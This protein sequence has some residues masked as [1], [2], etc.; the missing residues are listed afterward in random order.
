M[1]CCS[2]AAC[3]TTWKSSHPSFIHQRQHSVLI[4][5][6]HP[7]II[8]AILTSLIPVL[9]CS[10]PLA[11]SVGLA[12]QT[13]SSIFRRPRGMYFSAID[14][15]VMHSMMWNWPTSDVE[16]IVVTDGSR[17]LGLGDLG[18]NGMGIP[19]GKLSLYTAGAG[20]HP[21]KT[22]PVLID[23]GTNNEKLLDDPMYLGLPQKRVSGPEYYDIV[24]EFIQ[25]VRE[26]FPNALVQFE[27][28]STDKAAT[29]LEKYRNRLLCFNDDIQGTGCVVV[30]AVL[31]ALRAI[32]HER[33]GKA[34]KEQRIVVVGAGSAGLGVAGFLKFAMREEGLTESEASERFWVLDKDGVLGVGREHLSQEQRKWLRGSVRDKTGLLDVVQ[35]VQPTILIGLT[36]VG[37]IFN[38]EVIRAMKEHCE[39]PIILALSNPTSS[40]ECTAE[41][42][43]RWTDGT[44]LFACGSPFSPVEMNGKRL[45]PC[46]ANNMYT[47]P[48]IGLGAL[49][50]QARSIS[51]SMIYAAAKGLAG[52]TSD[53]D[54]EEGRIFPRQSSI[55][56]VSERVALAMCKQ[57]VSEGLARVRR[58]DDDK[59]LELIRGRRWEPEYGQIVRMPV[60]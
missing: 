39:R 36:A 6:P 25:A 50:C 7:H 24:D 13:F 33:P 18:T 26:R 43:Y 38:E 35:Q 60:L 2:T 57:A 45:V 30:A 28:F 14:K 10:S 56:Q 48:G 8:H 49:A 42:A 51:D 40:A 31:G 29:L 27:D 55:P 53:K 46:Q 59:W 3:S 21:S 37:G 5:T 12:C 20:I 15:G 17:I 32:G 47:F 9:L 11:W 52:A 41:D 23:V 54:F 1:R 44:A 58:D 4:S 34:L 22:L 19:I 16:I